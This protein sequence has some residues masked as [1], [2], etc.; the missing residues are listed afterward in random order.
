M[1]I[2]LDTNFRDFFELGYEEAIAKT[3]SYDDIQD[4]MFLNTT[5]N[6]FISKIHLIGSNGLGMSTNLDINKDL[7]RFIMDSDIGKQF[8]EK[9]AQFLW[10]GE[11]AEFDQAM[12][13][14]GMTYSTDSYS[15]SII[16]KMND[17][18]GF[19][20]IDVS[21]HQILETFAEYDLGKGSI[22]GYITADGRE[23]LAN[24]EED[25]IFAELPYYKEALEAEEF[26]GYSDEVYQGKSYLFIY[27]KFDGMGGIVCALVPRS[28]ILEEV[29]GLKNINLFFVVT[30]CMIAIII[31]I[32]IT[33]GISKTIKK[34]NHPISKAAKGDLTV[35]F[36]INRRDEFRALSIGISDMIG[37][38]RTL[39]GE[40]QEV[41]ST[42]SGSAISLT[43]T[44]SHLLDATKGI[45]I[46]ID[47]IGQGIIQQVEDTELCLTQMSNLSDQITQVYNNTN[48][49][50]QIA[51]S[52][53]NVAAEGL[54]MIEELNHKAK[55]TSEVTK[56]V[57][58]KI[59]EFEVQSKKIEGFVRLI[60]DIAAQTNLLS[61]NASIEA[62]RAGE[63]GR[64][65]AVVA[66]EIRKL[67][68]QSMQAANQIQ[69]TVKDIDL[70]NRETVATAE[71]AE[72]IVA[73][74][75]EA[76]HKT[77]T[78][79]D[80]I[81]NH[82]NS[83]ATNLNDILNRLKAIET[84]KDDTL[85]AIQNISAVSEETAASTEEVNATSINQIESVEQ[86]QKSAIVLEEQTR[87]LR[88]AISI[89]LIK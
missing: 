62:S 58:C 48:E 59:Q 14:T 5:S 71:K 54:L 20:I 83:L 29:R 80:N 55:A 67:A 44:S 77:V 51:G 33:R 47:E 24:T 11:H 85:S 40:V 12:P 68:D 66:G 78:V 81:S 75:T 46:T 72:S 82:V 34:I 23:T 28:T 25:S 79:F 6:K 3:K 22:M 9:R 7:Y 63:A 57:I 52:T 42:V 39:I 18:K 61:L 19:I 38:M 89:F 88:D 50:E 84:A 13:K 31:V 60:N 27:S 1:E 43:N 87:K 53:K 64:G 65:F 69:S 17:S 74:Q 8:K 76:L 26:S 36:D 45:S 37:H 41:G 32:F 2:I 15:A 21:K 4:R 73:S 35:Q 10:L 56:D 49:I 30:A 16:R 70:K 86:L